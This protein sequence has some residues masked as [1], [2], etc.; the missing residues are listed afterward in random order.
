[1]KYLVE[2]HTPITLYSLDEIPRTLSLR[3]TAIRETFEESGILMLQKKHD[4]IK[5]SDL[6][7]KNELKKWRDIVLQEPNEFYNMCLE[8]GALP[9]INSLY[10]WSNWLTPVNRPKRFDVMFFLTN[11]PHLPSYAEEDG[12]ELVS[13]DVM[14]PMSFIREGKQGT[15]EI[16]PPQFI[17]LSRLAKMPDHSALL[18]YAKARQNN[19]LQQWCPRTVFAE[20]PFNNCNFITVSM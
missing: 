2:P 11:L 14:H 18:K 15:F 12:S 19:G 5:E 1:M 6:P 7:P 8:L 13:L 9:K 16:P 17:E 10:E 3:I 4:I 20:G